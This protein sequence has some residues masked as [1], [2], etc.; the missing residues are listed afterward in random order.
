M[1]IPEK[2]ISYNIIRKQSNSLPCEDMKAL[3][4]SDLSSVGRKKNRKLNM[5]NSIIKGQFSCGLRYC[6]R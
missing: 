5:V 3:Q 1:E 2:M 6:F 4:P